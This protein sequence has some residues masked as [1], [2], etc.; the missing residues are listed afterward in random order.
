MIVLQFTATAA[1]IIAA[2]DFTGLLHVV[3]EGLAGLSF[4]KGHNIIPIWIRSK[5]EPVAKA[6]PLKAYPAQRAEAAVAILK[7]LM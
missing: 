4:G 3:G 6:L 7:R 1:I 5:I 2:Q